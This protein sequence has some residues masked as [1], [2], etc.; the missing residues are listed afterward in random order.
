MQ[1]TQNSKPSPTNT[2]QSIKIIDDNGQI[3][4]DQVE[5][6]LAPPSEYLQKLFRHKGSGSSLFAGFVLLCIG[7]F[8]SYTPIIFFTQTLRAISFYGSNFFANAKS[9]LF[10]Y[11]GLTLIISLVLLIIG[12]IK[13]ISGA[14]SLKTYYSQA[15]ASDR[16]IAKKRIKL[17]CICMAVF[18]TIILYVALYEIITQVQLEPGQFL[19]NF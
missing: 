1:H 4:A 13:V 3:I 14:Q 9:F 19:Y 12:L 18:L 10:I 16:P 7:S 15:S 11:N 6:E 8:I 5:P 17:Y 2:D